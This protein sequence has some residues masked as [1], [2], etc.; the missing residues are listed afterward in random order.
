[1]NTK[2][3][4]AALSTIRPSATFLSVRGY[5][6]N[7]GEVSDF[8]IV[9]NMNYKNALQK[10]LNIMDIYIPE[11]DLELEAKTAL[12][13]SWTKSLDKMNT[14]KEES[15]GDAYHRVNDADGNPIS[16]VKIHTES[17]TLHIYGLLN[18]KKVHVPVERKKKN[19]AALTI[20]KDKLSSK[21]HVPVSRFRQFVITPEK[22]DSIIVEKMELLPP[23]S[24][25]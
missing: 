4:L 13:T 2:A 20:A 5:T 9:F 22:V 25:T 17:N 12:M 3:F 19:S 18:S 7:E 24:L 23:R 15:V 11:N 16:G 10:S 8:S 14:T 1:M 6:S 21:L